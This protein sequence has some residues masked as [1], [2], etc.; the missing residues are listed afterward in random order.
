[1]RTGLC[2]A[3]VQPLR[4]DIELRDPGADLRAARLWRTSRGA[5]NADAE[6]QSLA[7]G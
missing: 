1:M 7:A 3:V 6:Q 5:A 4:Y 2:A